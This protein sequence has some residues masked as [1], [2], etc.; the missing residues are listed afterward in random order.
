L[1]PRAPGAGLRDVTVV[2]GSAVGQCEADARRRFATELLEPAERDELR[3]LAETHAQAIAELEE[4]L[5]AETTRRETAERERDDVRQERRGMVLLA[6]YF[7]FTVVVLA[8][9]AVVSV[10]LLASGDDNASPAAACGEARDWSSAGDLVGQQVALSGPV[11]AA[12]Y[13]RSSTGRTT[14]IDVG[15]RFPDANRLVVVVW[16]RNRA[17]FPQPPENTYQ[18]RPSQ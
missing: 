12:T 13:R 18:A 8:I 14:F 9:A 2:P 6:R 16:G 5:N 7:T 11:V 15:P 3:R 17:A 10:V 4:R 1:G